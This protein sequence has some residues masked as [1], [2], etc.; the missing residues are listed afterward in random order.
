MQTQ[1]VLRRLKEATA[2][3]VPTADASDRL[4]LS[5]GRDVRGDYCHN[6]GTDALRT[7]V[8]RRRLVP[9]EPAADG[10]AV[11]L[12]DDCHDDAD[13]AENPEGGDVA[14]RLDYDGCAHD[15]HPV[16]AAA[17]RARD[18]G[19]CRGCGVR[20]RIVVG[21]D[22]HLHPVVPIAGDGFRHAH[23]YVCLCPT[24]HRKVHR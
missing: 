2:D 17:V 15:A 6:C 1:D 20:E 7:T 4:A 14:G 16:D 9:E 24:C 12:C 22:L 5:A 3:R 10:N 19:R 18:D 13:T 21:D 11:S 8:E 23:N